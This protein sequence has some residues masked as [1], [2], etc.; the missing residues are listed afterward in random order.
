MTASGEDGNA[1]YAS[2]E[3]VQQAMDRLTEAEHQKLMVIA[4]S[5]CKRRGIGNRRA[6]PEE[7]LSEAVLV[8]LKGSKRWPY[9]RISLIKHLDQAMRNIS[10]HWVRDAIAENLQDQLADDPPPEPATQPDGQIRAVIAREE[11]TAVRDIFR[12]DPGG[13]RLLELRS[14][15][16]TRSEIIEELGIS[17]SEYE[18]VYKRVYRRLHDYEQ[19]E[20]V[21]VC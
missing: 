4:A 11:L 12:G 9:R 6:E 19:K 1:N 8:T 2:V 5:Y 20:A 17:D 15:G 7:L 10:G 13:M 3:I 21:N 16:S 18:A 14:L